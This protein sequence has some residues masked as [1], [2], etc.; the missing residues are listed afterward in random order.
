MNEH[1]FLF[2]IWKDPQSRSNYIVGKLERTDS[3]Y[4]FEYS[5]DYKEAQAAGWNLIQ[6]FPDEK[7]YE[8]EVLFPVFASRLPDRKRKNI[9]EILKKYGLDVYDGYELLKQ[10]GGR[11]PIDTFEFIDPIFDE[12]KTIERQFFVVGIRH[13]SGC[14]GKECKMRPQLEVGEKLLLQV[15]PSNEYDPFAVKVLTEKNEMIGYI[16]RYYSKGVSERLNHNMTYDCIVVEI[17]VEMDCQECVKVKL[18]MPKMNQV[19]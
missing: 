10:G 17:G 16:P 5:S 18:V 13:Q 6:S 14:G 12:D 2:L 9:D 7:K 11:L 1:S 8:S 19:V 15:E 3:G 4:S